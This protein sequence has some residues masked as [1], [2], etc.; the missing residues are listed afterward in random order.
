MEDRLVIL[1]GP[2]KM[3][4]CV[5]GSSGGT[6]LFLLERKG[7]IQV[8]LSEARPDGQVKFGWVLNGSC[9]VEGERMKFEGYYSTKHKRGTCMLG[10]LSP[11]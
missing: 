8:S 4:T 7:R 5:P 11:K 9:E 2:E 6:A 3:E 10:K 1:E